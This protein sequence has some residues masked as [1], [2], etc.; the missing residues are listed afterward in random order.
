[1]KLQTVNGKYTTDGAYHR[2]MDRNI[3]TESI[4]LFVFRGPMSDFTEVFLSTISL[5]LFHVFKKSNFEF[6][7]GENFQTTP[8]PSR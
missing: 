6:P 8:K 7:E 1:M 3:T 4:G 5:R 2:C